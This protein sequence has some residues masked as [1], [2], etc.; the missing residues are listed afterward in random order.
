MS[1]NVVMRSHWLG[2]QV[3]TMFTLIH[4]RYVSVFFVSVHLEI[5]DF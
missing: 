4:T 3:G 2:W 5:P 1:I